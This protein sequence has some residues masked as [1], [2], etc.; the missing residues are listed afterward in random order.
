MV[1]NVGDFTK[2]V[3]DAASYYVSEYLLNSSNN[4]DFAKG[5]RDGHLRFMKWLEQSPSA[6]Q[7]Q[8]GEC[9]DVLLREYG[10]VQRAELQYEDNN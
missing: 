5:F 8:L 9:I 4:S 3:Q 10:N 7:R 6:D 1:N 2:V